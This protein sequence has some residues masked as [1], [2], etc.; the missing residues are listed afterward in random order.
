MRRT[1]RENAPSA[2][3]ACAGSAVL[4]WLT[5]GSYVWNDYDTEA[6]PAVEALV[7]GHLRTFLD[8]APV[9]G[10]SLL[11]RA[12]LALLPGLWSGG[13]LAVYR[14]LALPA[15]A[16]SVLLGVWLA[17]RMRRRGQTILARGLAVALC[18]CNPVAIPALELG[19]AEE[20][21]G[22]CACTIAVLLATR[23][24]ARRFD[25]LLAGAVLGVAIA[26]KDWAVLAAGPV[27][28]ALTPRAR[29]AAA[30]AAV[31]VA[32]LLLSPLVLGA[33]GTFVASTRSLGAGASPI[34]QP[35]Q[36]W[37]FLGHHGALVR[38]ISGPKP[39]YRTGPA[40]IESD[41]HLLIVLAA[42]ALASALWLALRMRTRDVVPRRLAGV[43]TR[44][45]SAATIGERARRGA[46]NGPVLAARLSEREALCALAVV[47][48]S[49]FMLDTWDF[50]YY[51]LPFL[52]A[53]VAWEVCEAPSRPPA[54]ALLASALVWLTFQWLPGRVSPDA[55]AAAFLLWTVPLAML[56]LA[57]LPWPGRAPQTGGA[58][59]TAGSR[60]SRPAQEMTVRSFG[61]P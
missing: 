14:L 32:G 27:L 12:P 10:G 48:M 33:S 53:L 5:L 61:S 37:W 4:A 15:L 44:A 59:A 8:L 40:W 18:V 28:L 25:G 23:A 47:M 30:A 16:S 56:L 58:S 1:L 38:G 43:L 52:I 41:S 45:G 55:Q 46:G 50:V 22:A 9:Y 11:E 26:N 35:W 2:L 6:R 36:V 57:R 20:L 31:A 24:R 60:S 7:H 51:P 42:L 49:R 19:H 54:L 34:F 39:G 3:L 21:F 17:A 13:A 29:A